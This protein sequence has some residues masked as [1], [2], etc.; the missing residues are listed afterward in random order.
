M[1]SIT[2]IRTTDVSG[3]NGG[4]YQAMQGIASSANGAII[5]VSMSGVSG[6]GVIKSINNG[7]TWNV[8]N[9]TGSFT[10]ICCSS[11]GTIVYAAALGTGLYTSTDSGATWNQVTFA[12]NTLPGG[13]ANPESPAGGQFPGYELTNLYQIACD[14]TGTKLLMTTNAAASLYWSV[15]SGVT[16]SFLY[17][18]AG[19]N[20]NPNGPT[21][22]ACNA[23]GTT[24]YAALNTNTISKII[25]VSKD[26][27]VTWAPIN[28][29]G[30]VGPFSTLSTN[31]FGDFVFAV[32]SL[33]KLNIFY[34]THVDNAVLIPAGGNT[35]VALTNYND[36]A[37]LVITQNT[38]TYVNGA[39]VVYSVTN[40]YSPG[41]GPPCFKEGTKILCFHDGQEVYI[42]I[43]DIRKGTL[44]KTLKHGYVPVNM[45][46]TSRLFNTGDSIRRKD[47]L[48]VCSSDKYPDVT[49][50]LIITGAHSILEDTLTKEQKEGTVEILGKL[51]ITDNKYRLMAC[52]DERAIPYLEEGSFTIWHIALDN[53]NNYMNYGIYANGLLVETCS[54]RY[55]KESS[56]MTLIE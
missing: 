36:G 6:V 7:I 4:N 42:Q 18:P 16:W 33:S 10:S 19:Y 34:P 31:A 46:G 3:Y 2:V 5:Y 50:D 39:V 44:V 21:T 56:G 27:G 20:T 38:P 14:S 52:L 26:A 11:G 8:V 55:L 49:E 51:F 41:Q 40:K 37:N 9:T 35:Y 12:T 28:M 43:Q 30:L 54:K 15:D 13:S 1:A 17:V 53:D 23:D 32:D 48:Y 25:I 24:L 45:I 47:R 29:L 22:V